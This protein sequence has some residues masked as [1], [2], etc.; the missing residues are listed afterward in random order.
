MKK[1]YY[2]YMAANSRDTVL[3]TGVTNDINRRIFEHKNKPIKGFTEKYNVD[4]LVYCEEFN[5]P[6]GAIA[7][8][9]R[10]KGWTRKKKIELIKSVNPEFKDLSL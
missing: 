7:A 9:K 10:I 2:V 4:K 6:E 3:Y 8:E 1:K 5:S